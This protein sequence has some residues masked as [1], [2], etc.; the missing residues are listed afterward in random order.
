MESMTL[1]QLRATDT[2]KLLPGYMHKSKM[3]R[4]ELIQALTD[5]NN[6]NLPFVCKETYAL[7]N[8]ELKDTLKKTLIEYYKHGARS[9]KKLDNLHFFINCII[10][11][12]IN[13][14][15]P[16]IAKHI[17]IYSQPDKEMNVQGLLYGKDVDITVRYKT[18]DIGLVSVK[19]IMSNYA[20]NANNYFENLIGDAVNLKTYPMPRVFWYNMLSFQNIPYYDKTHVQKRTEHIQVKKYKQL[21]QLKSTYKNLPDYISIT[22]IQNPVNILQHPNKVEKSPTKIEDLVNNIIENE[23]KTEAPFDFWQNLNQFCNR[24]VSVIQTHY[25]KES[26][27]HRLPM[28]SI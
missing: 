4:E 6:G 3:K 2:Y 1:T 27:R 17:K 28:K 21:M 22:Y 18:H 10:R 19:F 20:Q 13:Q 14:I 26:S 23:I 9:S 8:D 16:T 5:A 12:R 11:F 7:T 15:S 24:V 25:D